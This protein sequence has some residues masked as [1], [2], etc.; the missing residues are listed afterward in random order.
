MFNAQTGESLDKTLSFD[1]T[2]QDVN[3]NPPIFKPRVLHV[4]VPE[5]AKEGE[6]RELRVFIFY[7]FAF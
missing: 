6:D 5:N 7:F 1:V 4:Q 3:D 2:V